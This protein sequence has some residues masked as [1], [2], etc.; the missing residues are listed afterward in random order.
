[1]TLTLS[2]RRVG[3]FSKF[4]FF[5]FPRKTGKSRRTGNIFKVYRLNRG[6]RIWKASH[7]NIW[8][9]KKKNGNT[10]SCAENKSGLFFDTTSCDKNGPHTLVKREWRTCCWLYNATGT[11][12]VDGRLRVDRGGEGSREEAM[13]GGGCEAG[14]RGERERG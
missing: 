13:Q 10:K 4:F 6:Q 3:I 2:T 8:G 14:N 12:G 7:S 1:M 11:A 9:K 5:C